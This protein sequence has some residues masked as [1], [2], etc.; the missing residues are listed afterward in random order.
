MW[1]EIF[2]V[3]LGLV[4]GVF[5]GAML[6]LGS[7]RLRAHRAAAH[8]DTLEDDS[9]RAE[10]LE[11]YR[12]SQ[13]FANIGTWD[14]SIKSDVLHW[15]DEIYRMFGYE[16]GDVTP[17]YQLFIQSLH[18]DDVERVQAAEKA[19]LEQHEPH[20]IEYRVMWP[21]GTVRWLRETGNVLFD[22]AGEA[23][24]FTGIVRDVTDS[25]S[26]IDHIQQLAHYDGLTGLANREFFREQFTEALARAD[27]HATSV[28]LIFMD[29][30]KFKPVNDTYGHAFGDKVL[31]AVAQNMKQLIRSVDKVARVG[32]DEFV[33]ILEDIKSADEAFTVAEKLRSLFTA[34]MVV[35]GRSVE[36]G[37]SIGVSLYPQDARDIE[38]LI[39]IADMAMYR[40][41]QSRPIYERTA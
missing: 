25:K 27:R 23:V 3:V 36:L 32:G 29:L 31:M 37:V 8:M 14:W 30:N 41:K 33:V 7:V 17:S 10:E 28:A 6:A 21:N 11:R 40:E 34:P 9:R 15:S 24:K 1:R 13:V 12:R 2:W 38:E 4:P 26:K 16:P 18:K 19:C 5:L 35:E 39:H 22:E 20:D